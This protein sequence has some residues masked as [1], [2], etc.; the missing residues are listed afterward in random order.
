MGIGRYTGTIACKTVCG[1]SRGENQPMLDLLRR[2]FCWT[3]RSL[4]GLRYR[5]RINGLEE[6]KRLAATAP[7]RTLVLPNHPALVD[8]L[9]LFGYLWP[10]LHMRPLAWEGNFRNPFMA[11][12]G[13]LSNALLS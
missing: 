3:F 1:D 11:V 9:I 2:F 10:I 6:V 4:L 7:G 13:K 8:P 5:V 12:L